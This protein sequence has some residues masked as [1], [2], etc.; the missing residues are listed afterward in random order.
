MLSQHLRG[1]LVFTTAGD[2]VAEQMRAGE[3]AGLDD[4]GRASALRDFERTG[5]GYADYPGRVG[6]GLARA[7]PEWV[8]TLAERCSLRVVK[9]AERAWGDRQDV[10]VARPAQERSN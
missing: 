6:Y 1:V 5:F 10:F 3:L 8:R 9:I 2:Y 7:K 4:A